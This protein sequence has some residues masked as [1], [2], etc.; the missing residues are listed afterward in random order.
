KKVA[1]EGR[2]NFPNLLR[3]QKLPKDSMFVPTG[4][5]GVISPRDP[6]RVDSVTWE[7]LQCGQAINVYGRH[8]LLMSC[9]SSTADWYAR[10]GIHQRTLTVGHEEVEDHTEVL[11]PVYNGYGNE[12]DLYA[13]GLSLEP[14][15]KE[16][17]QEE[18]ER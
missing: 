6:Q 3:R 8:L 12:D 10:R 7:D 5:G 16:V 2:H 18:Y 17:N 11:M 15:T 1:A 13:M 9:D 4:Y 14:L